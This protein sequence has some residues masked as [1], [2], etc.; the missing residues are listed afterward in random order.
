MPKLINEKG[1]V[2]NEAKEIF[3]KVSK[4]TSCECPHHLVDILDTI[5]K[6]TEYQKNCINSKPQ[7]EYIHNWL[8]ATSTNL[9]HLVSNTIM[10]LARLEGLVDENNRFIAQDE[11]PK[12]ED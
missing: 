2:T 5:Q 12:K 3:K 11:I 4:N 10:T 6:F 8:H 1:L 7:D 9:E